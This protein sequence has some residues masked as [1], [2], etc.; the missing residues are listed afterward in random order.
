MALQYRYVIYDFHWADDQHERLDQMVADGW[1]INVAIPNSLELYV[2]W[3][4][5]APQERR[6]KD[7]SGDGQAA[8]H[9]P[10]SGVSASGA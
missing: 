8:V 2:L 4:R 3:Q 5:E 10:A 7:D 9:P 6:K 1:E